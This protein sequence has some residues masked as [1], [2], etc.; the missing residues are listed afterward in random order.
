MNNEKPSQSSFIKV[1]RVAFGIF[2]S[3]LV[4]GVF[5][6]AGKA[7]LPLAAI[8]INS[9]ALTFWAALI[10]GAWLG[11]VPR[12]Y[13]RHFFFVLL[14][15]A[16]LYL[17]AALGSPYSARGFLQLRNLLSLVVLYW[18]ATQIYREPEHVRGLI[19]SV[20]LPF[21][22]L[23]VYGFFGDGSLLQ[24]VGLSRPPH[25]LPASLVNTLVLCV[26]GAV[27]LS[28]TRPF[29]WTALFLLPLVL[30][31]LGSTSYGGTFMVAAGAI[32]AL[33]LAL[34]RLREPRLLPGMAKTAVVI[35]ALA[36]VLAGSV[37]LNVRLHREMSFPATRDQLLQFNSA[38]STAQL[39]GERPLLGY[40]PGTFPIE[41]PPYWTPYEQ[42]V[43][44]QARTPEDRPASDLFAI[45]F[46]AGLP[47]LGLYITIF[48][49]ALRTAMAMVFRGKSQEDRRFGF[50]FAAFFFAFFMG[51]GI[52]E[53]L[54]SP[55]SA[56]LLFA[57]LGALDGLHAGPAWAGLRKKSYRTVV[58]RTLAM[59]AVMTMALY[60]AR[61]Y[62]GEYYLWRGQAA[63]KEASPSLA[64]AHELL[65]SG[66][67]YLPWDWRPAQIRGGLYFRESEYPNAIEGFERALRRN[68]NH[69]GTLL[70]L[71]RAQVLYAA[72]AFQPDE[73]ERP[74][75]R[76]YENDG[77]EDQA[78]ATPPLEVEP[79]RVEARRNAEGHLARVL[80]LSPVHPGAHRLLAS[81]ET[82]TARDL[83]MAAAPGER[84][85]DES[86]PHWKSAEEHIRK[87]M[88]YGYDDE[89]DALTVLADIRF[90][91]GA[92]LDAF[93][94]SLEA[95]RG[96]PGGAHD[97]GRIYE[98][99]SET[100]QF[101]QFR[102]AISSSIR[103]IRFHEPCDEE[104]LTELYLW[105]ARV[106]ANNLNRRGPAELAFQKAVRHGPLN[107]STWYSYCYFAL[108]LR[109]AKFKTFR[110]VL[111]DSYEGFLEEGRE[112]LPTVEAVARVWLDGREALPEA[113]GILADYLERM[114]SEP[115]ARG[116]LEENLGWA[117]DLVWVELLSA[118]TLGKDHVEETLR[119]AKV[120]AALNGRA[121]VRALLMR[122]YA[123]SPE[124][125]RPSWTER[126]IRLLIDYHHLDL[127]LDSVKSALSI[128]PEDI[129]FQEFYEEIMDARATQGPD[130]RSPS[131]PA[132]PWPRR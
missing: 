35:A 57:V 100:R 36:L 97:W 81:L 26:I 110:A 92:A 63:A 51:G 127:A 19:V 64:R 14:A 56:V 73:P 103:H 107:R 128:W 95:V 80:E 4:L 29:L 77:D 104:T 88:K 40:G 55:T 91:L 90:E 17:F 32:F 28:F 118:G 96:D 76:S 24:S 98:Y 38:L 8:L 61:W 71:A 72:A 120:F 99:S 15:F 39:I 11:K 108:P 22:L 68:P 52:G 58:L 93:E 47:A 86:T 42:S 66:E 48:M 20:C 18:V 113:I 126:S 62:A 78:E 79:A 43:F 82:F 116:S 102:E 129:R 31:L 123:D 125:E 84:G 85:D 50:F 105:A 54:Q 9:A 111:I 112:P 12:R 60:D 69:V 130:S 2:V 45:A 34:V 21:T 106:N 87:A 41:H 117:T 1:L 49:V 65:D 25:P 83:E 109:T 53:N 46:E 16:G 74:A 7:V 23:W 132:S 33:V 5:F 59:G 122:V 13:P 94:L 44:S 114:E 37:R 27:Y 124:S 67:H 10:C 121:A 131:R 115:K 89:T 101:F 70:S 3:S 75:F 30:L 119:F 6:A